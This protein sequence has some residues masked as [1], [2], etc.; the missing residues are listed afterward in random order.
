MGIRVENIHYGAIPVIT[1]D[2]CGTRIHSAKDGNYEWAGVS[3]ALGERMAI[4][5]LHKWCSP[6]HEAQHGIVLNSME[7]AVLLPQLA[8]NL[9]LDWGEAYS[10]AEMLSDL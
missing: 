4:Y 1:C 7:L 5:F 9:Q 10:H 2:Y 3:S 6:A 8:Q